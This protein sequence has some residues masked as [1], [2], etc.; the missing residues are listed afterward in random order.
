M[1]GNG[2]I[3]L[4][5]EEKQSIVLVSG[6]AHPQ[7]SQDIA[8]SMGVEL[9]P[10]DIG[11]HSNSEPYAHFPESIRKKDVFIIQPHAGKHPDQPDL[12][13]ADDLMMSLEMID[14]AVGA[15][16]KSVNLVA[17]GLAGSRQDRESQ[18][19][20]TVSS[21]LVIRM[22]K[23]AGEDIMPYLKLFT[24]DV[25]S[26]QAI[27]WWRT[28]EHLTAVDELSR[29]MR[30]G[31]VGRR[32]DYR[33]VPADNGRSAMADN[34]IKEN[35]L[36]YLEIAYLPGKKRDPHDHSVTHARVRGVKGKKIYLIDD[37]FDTGG[38]LKSG[39]TQ[40]KEDGAESI[41]AAA[42]HGWLSDPALEIM[43]ELLEE[44]LVNQFYIT[45]T[46]PTAQAEA[47]L[48]DGII[49]VNIADMVSEALMRK[50]KGLSISEQFDSRNYT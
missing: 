7:L 31:I 38:T 47:A 11:R 26:P 34:Y 22:I 25:H 35:N 19:G 33:L 13:V 3:Y 36:G 41:T 48:K 17:P 29:A 39:V 21:A 24:V 27:A 32:S 18:P 30:P 43:L 46:L 4:T 10:I 44:K 12:S 20:E 1:A 14:A 37:M 9:Y 23:A 28:T 2:E 42:T 15:E 40:L 49:V 50:I 45:N 6:D 5:E 16:A 8:D